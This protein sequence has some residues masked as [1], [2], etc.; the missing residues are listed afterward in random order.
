MTLPLTVAAPFSTGAAIPSDIAAMTGNGIVR[1][2]I[3]V[4]WPIIYVQDVFTMTV[5]GITMVLCVFPGIVPLAVASCPSVYQAGVCITLT[6]LY[7]SLVYIDPTV[8]F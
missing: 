4:G 6:C 1:D 2:S 5:V 3:T 8:S 7:P